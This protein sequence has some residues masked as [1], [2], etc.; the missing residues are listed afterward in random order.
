MKIL[1]LG[2][3]YV[4][5]VSAACFAEMGHEVTCLDI[6][7]EKVAGL[8]R[9]VV[10]IYEPGLSE[11]VC[12]NSDAGRLH[13]T[14][15]YAHAVKNSFCCFLALPTPSAPDASCDLSYVERGVKALAA[16]MDNYRI[17]VTKSTVPVGTS[18]KI[19]AWVKETLDERGIDVPFDVASNPEFLKEGDAIHDFMKPDRVI[20][21]VDN[22]SVASMLKELY[23]TFTLNHERILIMDTASAEMSKYAA[24]AMLATRISFMNELALLCEE[25]GADIR[26]VRQGIGSDTRIG[27]SFLYAGVGYGGSCFP[28]D[29]QALRAMAKKNHCQLAVIEA[30]S[31]ANERQKMVMAKKIENYFAHKGGLKGKTLAIWGLSFKPG[32]DDVR[33]SPALALVRHLLPQGCMLRLFD[34]VA[35]ERAKKE[36]GDLVALTWCSTEIDAVDGADAIVLMTEWKQFRHIDFK[37]I[38]EQLTGKAFFDGRNQY[39]PQEMARLGFEYISIGQKTTFKTVDSD[40]DT[41]RTRV[42]AAV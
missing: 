6:D 35:V 9:G 3:G 29:V 7:K 33:E 28:K 38:I 19:K 17:L 27:Y 22:P 8:R 25:V 40:H 10:P 42:E 23:S 11:M 18:L 37:P 34:P 16:H 26:Q 39:C 36:V 41:R 30:V 13:F 1:V 4:G 20:I 5:L 12:R 14:T 21:G 24:N 15:D 31:Q 2:A 32:T